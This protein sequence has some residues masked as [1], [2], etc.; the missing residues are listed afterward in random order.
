LPKFSRSG[1][2]PIVAVLIVAMLLAPILTL[3]LISQSE[4]QLA[5]AQ[6]TE[7]EF[8]VEW[9]LVRDGII[10]KEF[11]VIV[12]NSLAQVSLSIGP[13]F[14]QTN[15]DDS[16]IRNIELC[17]QV[18]ENYQENVIDWGWVEENVWDNENNWHLE[19][20][21][22]VVGSH[23]ENRMRTMWQPISFGNITISVGLNIF[24]FEFDTPIIETENGW[25]SKGLAR[26]D[27]NGTLYGSDYVGQPGSSWWDS[28]WQY[29]MKLT[30]DNSKIDDVLDN[31]PIVV[32][33]DN[34]NFD[35]T[36]AMDNGDDIRFVNNAESTELSYERERHDKDNGY[37]E[38]HVKIPSISSSENTI[39]YMYY[40]R[41]G[42]TD[43]ADPT[44]VWD[45]N[46]KLV[47]HLRDDPDISS[48]KDSTS[49]SN[50]GTKK[51]A[52]EPAVTT[53][54]KID[55]AQDCDGTD[56]YVSFGAADALSLQPVTYEVWVKADTLPVTQVV[57]ICSG[58]RIY[59]GAWDTANELGLH[60][61]DGTWKHAPD[62]GLSTGTWYYLT[63]T[64]P[65]SGGT[66]RF[67]R[68]GVE[69]ATVAAGDVSHEGG[70]HGAIGM[71]ETFSPGWYYPFDGIIDEARISNVVRSPAWIKA[72]FYSGDDNLLNYGGG[73]T[74][75]PPVVENI[76]ITDM[77]NVAT[78]DLTPQTPYKFRV[79]I[80]DNDNLSDIEDVTLKV[81]LDNENLPD[82]VENHYTFIWTKENGFE[83]TVSH[84][85]GYETAGASFQNVYDNICGSWFTVPESG[86]ANSITAYVRPGGP[87]SYRFAIYDMSDY[88]LVGYTENS[89]TMSPGEKWLTLDIEWG[90]TIIEA[91][92][93]G[94]VAWSDGA[95]MELFYDYSAAWIGGYVENTDYPTFPNFWNPTTQ[96][97]KYSIYCS[98]ATPTVGHLIV[99]NCENFDNTKTTD[100]IVFTFEFGENATLTANDNWDVWIQVYDSSGAQD[101][102]FFLNRFDVFREWNLIESWAG[103]VQAPAAWQLIESWTGTVSAPAAWQTIEMW[104]GTVS[105]PAQW[106]LIEEWTGTVSAP[107]EWQVVETWT[108]TVTAPAAWQIVETWTGTVQAPAEWELIETWTGI[109]EAPAAWQTIETWTGTVSAP[110]EWHL[111]ETW[112]GTIEA[113]AA[114]QLIESWTG[115]VSAPAAWSIVETWTGTI[116]AFAQWELVETWSGTLQAPARWIL[117]ES[118]NGTIEAFAQWELAESWSG[119][120][121]TYAEWSEVESWASTVQAPALR[122]PKVVVYTSSMVRMPSIILEGLKTASTVQV[123]G[124]IYTRAENGQIWCQVL[125]NFGQ[126][127][128]DA[129]VNVT[130]WCENGDNFGGGVMPYTAGSSGIY[131]HDFTAPSDYGVYLCDVFASWTGDNAYGSGEFQVSEEAQLGVP[132]GEGDVALAMGLLAVGVAV[133]MPFVIMAIRRGREETG[134]E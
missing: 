34:S 120:V 21:F 65:A 71:G 81:Y 52:G 83:N 53:D 43:G 24:K 95:I 89:G 8:T 2:T 122:L 16:L 17:K 121:E 5:Q 7:N 29:K 45:G 102:E 128:N 72:S 33:L 105:A 20:V 91:R 76:Y 97:R 125:D 54:G 38:Y 4:E 130:I 126:P 46:F 80:S 61:Y 39:F 109:V 114:W 62:G 64:V 84:K 3:V 94:L 25:G 99:E 10:R 1:K 92:N 104:T 69:K 60:F 36:H 63:G 124:T 131:T 93:Y 41:S 106:Q 86:V 56:D 73:E 14:V 82:A 123:F 118:W 132:I 133:C 48:C 111:I 23:L 74:L 113:P 107:A 40:S 6:P 32:F 22:G 13:K 42:T 115:T 35:W 44:N 9:H 26:F 110:A 96:Q 90:G 101:N 85:F 59:L 103:T 79:E 19:N 134:E 98:Y 129:S 30:I 27:V 51:G 11:E 100:N 87:A 119:T 88:A 77:D 50:D 70:A 68:D 67:Y 18:E 31:F 47:S 108:G 57:A 12:N 117:T 55:D 116:E 78:D 15:F 75:E 49:N 28:N 58:L 37:A 127:V 112:T 66:A